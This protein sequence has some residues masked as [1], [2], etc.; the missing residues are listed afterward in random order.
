[1]RARSLHVEHD[2]PLVVD[3]CGTGGDGA[4]TINVSTAAASWSR[5]AACTSPST[6]TAPP[7][8]CA[9]APTCSKPAGSRSTPAPNC[10]RRT[11]ARARFAFLFAPHY[12]PAMKEVGP[13]R[14]ELG[15]RTIFNVLG[16]LTNP[17]ARDPS[18]DRR[19]ERSAP[20]LV[21]RALES[22]RLG[23][24]APS[25]TRRAASTRSR[26]TPDRR[27]SV[28]PGGARRWTLDPSD[29]GI[30]APPARS[31]R[32]ARPSTRRHCARSSRANV[33]RA[34]TSS[35]QRRA[36]ARRRRTRAD[37]REGLALARD[38]H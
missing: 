38:E 12:H 1:M 16:P 4:H 13:V 14:R 19:R 28:R 33:L 6:A 7:R 26:A 20:R 5:A 30:D 25:C 37:L 22:A 18:G 3:T 27:V 17:A 23:R 34:R 2:L 36:R 31:R 35:P 15:V 29:F 24:P 21:G 32:R 10:A 8:A 9:A 11:R